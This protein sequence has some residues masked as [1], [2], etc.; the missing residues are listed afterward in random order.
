MA[1]QRR[2]RIFSEATTRRIRHSAGALLVT[3]C[4]LLPAAPSVMAQSSTADITGTVMDNTG[5]VVPNATITLTNLGTRETHVG[6]SGSDGDYSFVLLN[7]GTYSIKVAGSGFKTFVVPSLTLAASDRVRE[8]AKL[9]IGS[10]AETVQVTGQAPALQT[11]SSVLTN[12]V[13]EKAVQDL[14]LSGRNY[15]QLAQIV[16][17]ASE[18]PPN[19]LSSGERP[20]DRRQSSSFTANGQS[21]VVNNEVVD[22][23]DNNERIIGTIGVRPSVEAIR[24]ITVET[25]DYTA[26][27][28]RTGGAVI[29][30]ITKSGSNSFHGSAYEYFQNDVLN[31]YPYQFGANNPKPEFRQNQFGASIGGPII[32]DKTFFFAD[33][34][35]LRQVEGA[36]PTS[37]VVPTLAQYNA[38]R[39]DPASLLAP[40]AALDPVGVQYARLYP[41]PNAPSTNTVYGSYVSSPVVTRNSDTVDARVDHRFNQ[42]NLFYT[43]YTYNRVP[44]NFPGLL[45]VTNEAGLNIAPGGAIYNYYGAA[46]DD[47]QNIQLNYLHTFTPNLLL[48]LKFGYT[49]I[50][51]QSFPL[52]YGTAVNTA[53]GQPDVNLDQTTS[54]LAPVGTSGYADLGDGNYIPIIDVD[55]TFQY[56]GTVTWTKGA[57]TMKMGATLIR[58]QALNTQNNQGIGDWNFN[59]PADTTPTTLYQN[60]PTALASLLS[61]EFT[62]VQRSNNL[63]PPHYRIWEPSAFFQDD[64]RAARNLTLN[65]GI[66]YDVFTPFSEVHNAISNFDPATASI[67][68]ANQNGVNQYAGLHPTWT[69]VAPR[70]GFAFTPRPHLVL[71]GGFG[72]SYFPMNYT[73]NSNLKNQPFVSDFNCNNGACPGGYTRLAQGL[74]IPTAASATNPSG[75]IADTVDPNFRTSYLEQFNLTL[76]RDFGGNVFQATYVG[77]LGRHMAQVYSDQNTPAPV[78][79]SAINSIVATSGGTLNSAQAFN[80][81]R[82]FYSKLPNVTSIGGYN[83]RGASSYN[84][85]QLSLTRRTRAGLTV[86]AN[87]TFAHNL[88]NFLGISNE[89]N[90][91]YGSLPNEL[92]TLEYGNSDLDLRQRGVVTGDY[93]LPFGK[94]L[95]GITGALAKGWQ[96]NTILVW[97]TG[98]PFSITNSVNVVTT[99]PSA[100]V[101]RPNEVHSAK[102]SDPNVSRFFDA[103]AFQ[104]QLS[105][106][107]GSERRN[108]LYGPHFRHVDLSVFKT[109]PVYRES[110]IEFRAECFNIAN[111]ANFSAPNHSLQIA[112]NTD[113]VTGATLDTY[114]VQA[115]NIGTIT[116]LTP[117]YNPREFQFALKYQF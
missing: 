19:G 41:A 103:S 108:T 88:D 40:G 10:A 91:G 6:K 86:E 97:D 56:V 76:E 49:R 99:T 46:K 68:I 59:A 42:N 89:I 33:Y 61:G 62:S 11:D 30:I 63:I 74:P 107:V 104:P 106:T 26:E 67:V 65:L 44:S 47:A 85:L 23:L 51:N 12:T 53:F 96:A 48:E 29:N 77:E 90:D 84:A 50:D 105:G 117:S 2:I 25:N 8:D 72:I 28:G 102:V 98:T 83:S 73:S 64:W 45:P 21:D 5:A 54:G 43:R 69:N 78:S 1:N 81:L 22:G 38:L 35:G 14:P 37:S 36:N 57:H 9:E 17:G 3:G 112:P 52:N 20:D 87:Y 82:P 55:N 113:P 100:N 79:N 111:T 114:S 109:F 101:D 15:I 58:R 71:R 92:S 34:E 16:P 95:R 27:V 7:P 94:N 39:S 4:L 66:R 70:L 80:T 115:N 31:A 24:E 116:S 75:S 18:G 32:R 13:T 110:T 93:V 60:G